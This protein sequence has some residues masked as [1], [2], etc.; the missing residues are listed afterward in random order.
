MIPRSLQIAIALLLLVALGMG[1]YLLG[2][3][4]REEQRARAALDNRPVSAP[5]AG[6]PS[7]VVLFVADDAQGVLRQRDASIALPAEPAQRAHE[8]LHALLGEYTK[9]P[10]THELAAGADVQEVFVLNNGIAVVDMTAPFADAHRSGIFVETL[11]V[12]SLVE[13]L[14]ANVPGVTRVKILVEGK[15]RETLAGHAD[16]TT[17]YDV[18]SV[19]QLVKQLP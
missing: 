18:S 6:S 13:T 14:A 5:V 12:A 1:L 2:L 8:I 11:T 16:L 3:K 15:E 4:R 7:H 10:S 17:F 9:R 19:D